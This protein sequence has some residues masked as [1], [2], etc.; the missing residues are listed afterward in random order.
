MSPAKHTSLSSHL[1]PQFIDL[2][3][4]Y[5]SDDA[6]GAD[7]CQMGEDIHNLSVL[8]MGSDEWP[9]KIKKLTDAILILILNVML[10]SL[11]QGEAIISCRR[12]RDE[13]RRLLAELKIKS[14]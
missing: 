12:H 8:L 2:A 7:H 5:I 13:V 10:S 14:A 3:E 1:L 4:F 11:N 6:T 9:A